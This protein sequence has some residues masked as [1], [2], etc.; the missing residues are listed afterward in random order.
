MIQM[1]TVLFAGIL[2]L[3][4]MIFA[5]SAEAW[6]AKNWH[7]VYPVSPTVFEV[8]GQAGSGAADYWC[9]AGDYVRHS[10]RMPAVQRV[11]IWRGIG[12]SVGKSGRK[13]VQFSLNPPG[14]KV[15]PPGY[16]LS[17]KAVGDNLTAAA[18]FQYCL[19]NDPFDPFFRRP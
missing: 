10:L 13:A 9:G 7:Q 3:T 14:D 8:V 16:S 4:P 6:Q 5:A 19:D 2:A 12:P 18:A 15:A 17:V 11:Y 1:K